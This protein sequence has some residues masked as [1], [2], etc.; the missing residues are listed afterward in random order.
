LS[1]RDRVGSIVT[2]PPQK[3][4]DNNERLTANKSLIELD[5][6]ESNSFLFYNAL[7]HFKQRRATIIRKM[8]EDMNT[9]KKLILE[10]NWR[11]IVFT[12]L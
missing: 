10:P 9:K 6:L 7:K 2:N 11:L 12:T 8:K 3:N 5:S 4:S 1:L